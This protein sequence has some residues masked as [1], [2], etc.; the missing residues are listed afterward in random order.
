MAED[1]QSKR[2]DQEAPDPQ[3]VAKKKLFLM[4]AALGA[5][6][7]APGDVTISPVQPRGLTSRLIRGPQGG[8]GIVMADQDPSDTIFVFDIDPTDGVMRT[9]SDPRDPMSRPDPGPPMGPV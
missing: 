7:L 6:K 3:I 2:P 5:Q 4:T 1:E 9:D 8:P